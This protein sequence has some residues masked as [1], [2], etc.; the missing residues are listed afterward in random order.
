MRRYERILTPRTQNTCSANLLSL[1]NFRDKLN[2][3]LLSLDNF[4]EKQKAPT[5]VTLYTSFYF[6]HLPKSE[7]SL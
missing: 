6:S 1:D 7:T 5:T 2:A 3:N 4:R